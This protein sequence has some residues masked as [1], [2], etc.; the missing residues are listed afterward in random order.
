MNKFI[1]R[2]VEV[3][4]EEHKDDYSIG[5]TGNFLHVKVKG[6]YQINEFIKVKI[7][8]IDY[9]YCIGNKY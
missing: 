7:E 1:N 6:N 3:L 9:P 8:K 4:V 2:E 5:H